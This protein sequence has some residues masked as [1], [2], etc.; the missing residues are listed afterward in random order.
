[1]NIK[2]NKLNLFY[3]TLSL[4][5][6]LNCSAN[7]YTID[8]CYEVVEEYIEKSDAKSD[9]IW[10]ASFQTR[11]IAKGQLD[12]KILNDLIF[13]NRYILSLSASP[14]PSENTISGNLFLLYLSKNEN[15][16]LTIFPV[17]TTSK[18]L[19]DE[20]YA[21]PLSNWIIEF[22]NDPHL[23]AVQVLNAKSDI[24]EFYNKLARMNIKSVNTNLIMEDLD[25][26]SKYKSGYKK[27]DGTF[28][29]EEE[30]YLDYLND[31]LEILNDFSYFFVDN[32]ECEEYVGL[33]LYPR[34]IELIYD[35]VFNEIKRYESFSLDDWTIYPSTY[36]VNYLSKAYTFSDF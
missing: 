30:L 15:D 8:E 26:E 25:R 20:N 32:T 4:L 33:S 27:E 6:I 16:V 9:Y 13:N 28:I 14:F 17:T 21:N 19:I 11:N 35:N 22:K 12:H 10:I 31:Y 36:E 23:Y 18:K 5:I 1:M 34:R 29:Y 7:V 24:N 3:S 2:Y